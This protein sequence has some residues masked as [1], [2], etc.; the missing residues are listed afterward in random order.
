MALPSSVRAFL[1]SRTGTKGSERHLHGF[2]LIEIMVALAILALAVSVVVPG[3]VDMVERFE[4]LTERRLAED[5]VN[6]CK[7]AAVTSQKVIV[8]V[9]NEAL[10]TGPGEVG[11]CGVLP[12]GWRA[13]TDDEFIFSPAAVCSGTSIA[14]IDPS[15]T[16][17]RYRLDA[18][19]CRLSAA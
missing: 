15:G 19:T 6:D 16:R 13:Q 3:A 18:S 14:L 5:A 9:Q 8:F 10:D 12:T 7:L 11:A 2:S 4:R 1:Q 17:F